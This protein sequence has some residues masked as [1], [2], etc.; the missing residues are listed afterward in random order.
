MPLPVGGK[1]SVKNEEGDDGQVCPARFSMRFPFCPREPTELVEF[2]AAHDEGGVPRGAC[3]LA[4]KAW[5][6]LAG[7]GQENAWERFL[8]PLIRGRKYNWTGQ[9]ADEWNGR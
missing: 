7:D 2:V 3:P 9:N 8:A 4:G 5:A 6:F 1:A